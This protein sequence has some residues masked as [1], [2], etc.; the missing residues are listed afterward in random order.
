LHG[1]PD[2]RGAVLLVDP[3]KLATALGHLATY[4]RCTF[5]GSTYAAVAMEDLTGP[6]QDRM[7][8]ALKEQMDKLYHRVEVLEQ[9]QKQGPCNPLE[10]R[11]ALDV[12]QAEWLMNVLASS[13]LPWIDL[14]KTA[15]GASEEGR[16]SSVQIPQQ[17]GR[18][19]CS[20]TRSTDSPKRFHERNMKGIF[21]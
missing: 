5:V 13:N 12:A 6:P 16:V 14:G 11:G 15:P 8:I 9:Q 3:V 17:R 2:V 19:V 21:S 10:R 1:V 4:V 7:I 20:T 18:P